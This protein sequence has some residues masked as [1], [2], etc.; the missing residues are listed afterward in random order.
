MLAKKITILSILESHSDNLQINNLNACFGPNLHF[1]HMSN[2]EHPQSGGIVIV[3]NLNKIHKTPSN[4]TEINP[5]RA[6]SYMINWPENSQ[7]KLLTVYVPNAPLENAS[8]WSHITTSIKENPSIK[9]DII[10]GDFNMVEDAKDCLPPH[11]DP[12]SAVEAI[13]DLKLETNLIDGW[14]KVNPHPE[15]DFTFEQPLGGSRS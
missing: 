14:R 10:L 5:R 13:L 15:C 7:T 8:F 3:M 1:T 12:T 6:I 4:I 2:R 11:P 9:P